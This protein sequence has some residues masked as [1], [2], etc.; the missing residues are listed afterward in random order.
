M[1]LNYTKNF[2]VKKTL[3]KGLRDL[4]IDD[5]CYA[6]KKIGIVVDTSHFKDTESLVKQLESSGIHKENITVIEYSD[7]YCKSEIKTYNCFGVSDLKWNGKI[8]STLVND[9]INEDFDLL[10]SYYDIE[11]AI[12]LR[13]THSSKAVFKVGFSSI[14]KRLNHLMIETEVSDFALFIHELFKYLKVLNKI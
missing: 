6:I 7:T 1:F 11:K 13:V 3:K 9:F 12:L 4:K 5:S 2:I 14:D 8:S 10:I